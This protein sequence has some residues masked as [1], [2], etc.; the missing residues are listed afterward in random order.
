[1]RRNALK[2][3][4]TSLGNPAEAKSFKYGQNGLC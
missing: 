4:K 3:W 2:A 1:M